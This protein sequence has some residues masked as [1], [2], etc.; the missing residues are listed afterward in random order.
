MATEVSK[1]E[2]DLFTL[3]PTQIALQH[4]AYV[5]TAPAETP[6][7]HRIHINYKVSEGYMADMTKSYITFNAKIEGATE[8]ANKVG[9]VNNWG[10]SC[11]EQVSIK[12]NGVTLTEATNLYPYEAMVSTIV[13]YGTDAKKS[14][15]TLAGYAKDEGGKMNHFDP[16]EQGCNSGLKTRSLL[17]DEGQMTEMLIRPFNALFQ[18]DRLL[19]GG[20]SIDITLIP[21]KSKFNLMANADDDSDK[22]TTVISG[23]ELHVRQVK[24]M[25]SVMASIVTEREKRNILL[26]MRRLNTVPI[27]MS[28][29]TQTLTR[30]ISSGVI[31]RRIWCVMVDETAR[32]GN[33]KLNPFNFQHFNMNELY[34]KVNSV[35]VPQ[36]HFTPNFASNLYKECYF[37]LFSQMGCMFD[38]CGMDISYDDY[39]NGHMILC[40]D[41]TADMEDGDHRELRKTGDVILDIQLNKSLDAAVD[42]LCI[43]EFDTVVEITKDNKMFIQ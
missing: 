9:P 22:Y 7:K 21:S 1:S 32:Y 35:H 15:L 29:G 2:L 43:Q 34:L 36:K 31:P 11:F 14:H 13:S 20:T 26:P 23:L 6:T 3:P 41:L 24:V 8:T 16:S 4:G 42:I 40:F 30:P 12:V 10:H 18:Q 25:P 39:K 27:S 19:P 17:V 5:S 33:Y 37:S 28:S 38:D